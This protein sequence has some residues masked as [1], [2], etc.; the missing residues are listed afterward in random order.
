MFKYMHGKLWA[1]KLIRDPE[2]VSESNQGK[3]SN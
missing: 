1:T 3:E 2:I